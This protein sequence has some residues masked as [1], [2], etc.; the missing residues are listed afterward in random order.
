MRP[1][2]AD[3]AHPRRKVQDDVRPRVRQQ[4]PDRGQVAQIVILDARHE[5]LSSAA[6]LQLLGDD[7]SQEARAAGHDDRWLRQKVLL[8]GQG[9]VAGSP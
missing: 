3:A 8:S 1:V 9:R 4:A 7:R 6:G 2:G 5:D